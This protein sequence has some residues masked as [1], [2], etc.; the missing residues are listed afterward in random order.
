MRPTAQKRRRSIAGGFRTGRGLA[1]RR[2]FKRAR[3][4]GRARGYQRTSGFYGRFAGAGAELK[5]LDTVKAGTNIDNQGTMLSSSLNVIAQGNGENERIGRKLVIRHISIKG[6]LH[7]SGATDLIASAHNRLRLLVV[8]DKQCN[9]AAA[10]LADII[11]STGDVPSVDAHRDLAN[12]SRFQ[13]LH[14]KTVVFNVQAVAQTAAGIYVTPQI[15]KTWEYSK[16]CNVPI[17]YDSVTTDG[18]IG[19]IRSNNL[20]VFAVAQND[21]QACAVGYVCRVRFSDAM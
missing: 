2:L 7:L 5:F 9:G 17:E 13:V 3:V 14:D 18:V 11:K 16:S 12:M 19:T 21:A 8:L 10:T 1:P 4:S 15:V 6:Q 20:L